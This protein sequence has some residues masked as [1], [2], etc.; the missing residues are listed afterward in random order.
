M[1]Y[2]LLYEVPD[3]V[4]FYVI[5]VGQDRYIFKGK[6][7]VRDINCARKFTNISTAHRYA[8]SVDRADY[9]LIGVKSFDVG[10]NIVQKLFYVNHRPRKTTETPVSED[11]DKLTV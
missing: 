6:I 5:S 8:R 7:E 4:D 2:N 11:A 1:D 10:D 3:V 9:N